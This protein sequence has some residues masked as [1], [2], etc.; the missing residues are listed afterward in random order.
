MINHVHECLSIA[1]QAP[2]I[3]I[4]RELL[5]CEERVLAASV[6]R[7]EDAAM[8]GLNSPNIIAAIKGD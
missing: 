8:R 1:H 7:A 3:C 6:Q 4:C 2:G 5:A